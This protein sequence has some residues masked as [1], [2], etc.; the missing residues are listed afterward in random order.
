MQWADHLEAGW[1]DKHIAIYVNI[2]GPVLG[3]PKAIT[4]FLSGA[5]HTPDI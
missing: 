1:T 4:A 3:V 5:T 2:A